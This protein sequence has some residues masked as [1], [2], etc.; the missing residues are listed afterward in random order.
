M[1]GR[2]FLTHSDQR[3]GPVVV[4]P[5]ATYSV[6]LIPAFRRY[7]GGHDVCMTNIGGWYKREDYDAQV[8]AMSSSDSSSNG[9][10]RDLVRMMKCWQAHCALPLKSFHIELFA[11][12]FLQTWGSRG[13][14]K[15][16][17]DWIC[18]DFFFYL[19][20]RQNTT[21][22]APGTG[23]APYPGA[24]WASR[25]DTALGRARKACEYEASNQWGLAGDEWQKIFGADIPRNP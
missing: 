18:R 21:L 12:D 11:I 4:V 6:E 15:E 2:F 8:A 14:A 20:S 17:Y 3:S 25:A 22:Y 1:C 23:E 16:W 5:F 9:N 24:L 7:I 19:I 10:T 13:K